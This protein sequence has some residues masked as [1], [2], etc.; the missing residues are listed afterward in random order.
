MPPNDYKTDVGKAP[1]LDALRPFAPALLAL[2]R[3]MDDMQHKHRL[4]GAA[5]PFNEWRQLPEVRKR[6]GNGLLRHVVG[7]DPWSPN[8][9]DALPGK[10]PHLHAVHG[11][12]NLLGAITAHLETTAARVPTLGPALHVPAGAD[13][14]EPAM[15]W[16][17]ECGT[18][19]CTCGAGRPEACACDRVP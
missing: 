9:A 19:R 14:R 17:G 16:T 2:A 3:M 5:D 6:L 18:W 15:Y 11:L 10:E 1:L 8:T 7:H 13:W 4:A 12:F